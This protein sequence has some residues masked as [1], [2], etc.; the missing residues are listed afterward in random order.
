MILWASTCRSINRLGRFAALLAEGRALTLDHDSRAVAFPPLRPASFF[1]VVVPP[2]LLLPP[3]PDFLPPL[4]DA[5][6]ELAI[7]EPPDSSTSPYLS[8]PRIAS[9]S[10]RWP[11]SMPLLPPLCA[12]LTLLYPIHFR[13]QPPMRGSPGA[14]NL[15]YHP[16]A[17][18]HTP[19]AWAR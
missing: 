11:T 10:S 19:A 7:L 3:E 12:L 8:G 14:P 5:L 18:F 17:G 4:L 13:T 1:C 9:R 15:G 2:C 16:I 6:G